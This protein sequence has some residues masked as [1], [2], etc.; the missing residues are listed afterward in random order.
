MSW[1]SVTKE[2]DP[3][4]HCSKEGGWGGVN[5]VNTMFWLFFVNMTPR[6]NWEEGV[7]GKSPWDIS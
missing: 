5:E 1:N 2:T 3:D 7:V 6:H 4:M